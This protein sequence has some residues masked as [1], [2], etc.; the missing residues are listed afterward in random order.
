MEGMVQDLL[1]LAREDAEA[2]PARRTPVDLDDVVLEEVARMRQHVRRVTVDTPTV[3]VA[4]PCA[5]TARTSTRLV[6][7]LLDNAVRLRRRAVSTW[8]LPRRST[9]ASS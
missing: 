9:A 7:N 4:L 6:R 5:A 1:F 8:T 2:P 3:S